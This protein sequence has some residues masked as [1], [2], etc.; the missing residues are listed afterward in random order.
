MNA[1]TKNLLARWKSLEK[2]EGL[3]VV[4]SRIR[5]LWFVGLVLWILVVF[6]IAYS[7]PV[8]IVALAAA[9]AGWAIA[10]TNALRSRLTQ[11]P[12]MKPYIDWRRVEEDLSRGDEQA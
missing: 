2:G 8:V 5:V 4:A 10:E 3:Q 12:L 6:G 1:H 7:W 11:W 9:A